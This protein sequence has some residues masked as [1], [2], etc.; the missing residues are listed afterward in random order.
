MGKAVYV[1]EVARAVGLTSQAIRYYEKLGLMG[2]PQRTQAGYRVY[3]PEAL[4]RVQFIKRA[5]KLGLTLKEI[6]EVLRIKY[7]GQSPCEC[8]RGTL[9]RKVAELKKQ[10]TE[11]EKLRREVGSSLRAS[12]KLRRLP[13]SASLICPII[14]SQ[15]DKKRR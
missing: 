2:K 8:V 14:E 15:R 4:S 3:S 11:M 13:H 10:I 5:Q 12:A 9:A 7:A 1:H 6:R